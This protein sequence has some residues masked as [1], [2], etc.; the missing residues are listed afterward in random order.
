MREQWAAYQAAPSGYFDSVELFELDTM[1]GGKGI[2]N[3][4][5]VHALASNSAD[6]IQWLESIGAPLP[7]VSS[8]GGASVSAFTAR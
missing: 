3:P 5:L 4:E 7:S 8:F 1:I 6:A 2:N